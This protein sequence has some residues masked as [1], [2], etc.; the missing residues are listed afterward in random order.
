LLVGGNAW[1][2]TRLG[3]GTTASAES[4]T[5]I[6]V[7]AYASGG[8]C[9]TAIGGSSRDT[10][11][12]VAL[13]YDA[14]AENSSGNF[15]FATALGVSSR[16]SGTESVALGYQSS[17]PEDNTV[18]VGNS[19]TKRRIVNVA[20]G[21]V[22]NDATTV[23]QL[24]N[25]IVA[26]TNG[27]VALKNA[28]G[29]AKATVYTSTQADKVAQAKI[30]ATVGTAKTSTQAAT[31]LFAK[32]DHTRRMVKQVNEHLGLGGQRGTTAKAANT[33]VL[34]ANRAV[35]ATT[36]ATTAT[37]A[38]TG[39]AVVLSDTKAAMERA[40]GVEAIAATNT[41]TVLKGGTGTTVQTLR[42]QKDG[43][44]GVNY[45][46]TMYD[47]NGVE[48]TTTNTP[49]KPA[50]ATGTITENDVTKWVT[51]VRLGGVAAGVKDNDA[52]NLKQLTDALNNVGG[53]SSAAA[54]ANTRAIEGNKRAIDGNTQGIA[55]T[56]AIAGMAPLP[57][58]AASSFTAG[59]SRYNG[60]QGLAA[61]FQQRLNANTVLKAAVGTG[62]TGQPVTTVGLSYTWGGSMPSS[63]TATTATVHVDMVALQDRLRST[64]TD[65]AQG[66][67]EAAR[68]K[69]EATETKA[70]LAELM[71][72]MTALEGRQVV[73]R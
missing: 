67:A 18:S 65:L 55:N 27:T 58:G 17:A 13:G 39:A 45:Q 24:N 33:V 19:G 12:G 40:D 49:T 20:N 48:M 28:A 25:A 36:A 26:N 71:R 57:A 42:D 8:G 9:S 37:D 2:G 3:A 1:A 64:E 31:G 29:T 50:G 44:S 53:S 43:N 23:S 46:T 14:V 61:G 30:D 22:A 32:T 69:A 6:G 54:K 7:N 16:A 41:E 60:K 15:A 63:T 68:A 59:I 70:M 66:R 34:S 47:A 73:S 52:V 11:C 4:E 72:R 62:T 38:I 35:D 51:D 56:A 21:T 10:S 5:A